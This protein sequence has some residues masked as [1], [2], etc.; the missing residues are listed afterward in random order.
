MPVTNEGIQQDFCDHCLTV[1]K[2]AGTPKGQMIQVPDKNEQ[3]TYKAYEAIPEEGKYNA[4]EAV[5]MCTGEMTTKYECYSGML[6][7]V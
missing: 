3:K 1:V 2:H 5:V 6:L 7:L 4:E